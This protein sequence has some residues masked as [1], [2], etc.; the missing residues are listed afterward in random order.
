MRL[1]TF[2]TPI[3]RR[4]SSLIHLIRV[5]D[6]EVTAFEAYLDLYVLTGNRTYLDAMLG[7]RDMYLQHCK[8]QDHP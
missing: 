8:P 7:A 6:Y 4:I 5:T 1:H 3:L 2:C